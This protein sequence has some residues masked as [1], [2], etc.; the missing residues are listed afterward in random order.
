MIRAKNMPVVDV[1]DIRDEL[2]A[3]GVDNKYADNVLSLM[4]DDR[5]VN[6]IYMSYSIDDDVCEKYYK[7]KEKAK[8]VQ[9]IIDM[10]REACPNSDRVLIDISW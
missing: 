2:I 4:F 1:W 9:M 3:R 5:Y 7:D 10:L 8:V 6:D